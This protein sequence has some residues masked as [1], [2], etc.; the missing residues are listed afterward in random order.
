MDTITC[1]KCK[2]NNSVGVKFC[3]NCGTSLTTN[4]RRCGTPNSLGVV[5]CGNCGVKLSEATFGIPPEE[6]AKWRDAFGALGWFEE[7]GPRT[8]QTLPQ[9][10]PPLDTLQEHLLF[11]TYSSG[12]NYIKDVQ[13]DGTNLRR[14][15]IGVIATSWRIIIV[16]TDK[17]SIYNFSYEDIATVEKPDGGGV[18]KDVRYTI[19]TKTGHTIGIVV[20]L[21]APGLLG[22]FAGFGNPAIASDVISHSRM[23]AEVI[24][25]LNLFFT[26]IVPG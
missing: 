9:L 12:R 15:H 14:N 22:A 6:A 10:Q 20:H 17:L 11:V 3:Q 8:K 19:H 7:L 26:R 13:V 2:Q 1:P 21:D 5:Y 23:A 4:C 16:D 18:M 25:F 24:K